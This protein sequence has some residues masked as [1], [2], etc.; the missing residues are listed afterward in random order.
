MAASK[1]KNSSQSPAQSPDGPT[2]ALTTQSLVEHALIRWIETL[3]IF[4]DFAD[5]AVSEREKGPQNFPYFEAWS[6]RV[7][8]PN[9]ATMQR[10]YKHVLE[11]PVP[12]PP[13]VPLDLAN[14]REL[15]IMA[16]WGME[17]TM[18]FCLPQELEALKNGDWWRN[19]T[20]D[21]LIDR[22]TPWCVYLSLRGIIA[23]RG[24]IQYEGAYVGFECSE[25]GLVLYCQLL[26]DQARY[27]G[28]EFYHEYRFE[29][30]QTLGEVVDN[31]HAESPF[32][33]LIARNLAALYK[34]PVEKPRYYITHNGKKLAEY[35]LP[36][37]VG[38]FS[39][40]FT[41]ET[42]EIDMDDDSFETVKLLPANEP[43]RSRNMNPDRES[44]QRAYDNKKARLHVISY[45]GGSTL[46]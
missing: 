46:N 42:Y 38:L 30:G 9:D 28:S 23:S 45:R 27:C 8:I 31:Y 18:C 12:L 35:I 33:D 5:V 26:T 10:D 39:D 16:A 2:L 34:D 11:M 4:D 44:I 24:A 40:D 17:S 21:F 6:R 43:I 29:R 41:K 7:F 13:L 20:T 22:F 37:L 32:P 19:Y 14:R 15:G 25:K 1:K 3:N 36:L